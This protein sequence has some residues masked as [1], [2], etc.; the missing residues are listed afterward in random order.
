MIA[1]WRTMLWDWKMLARSRIGVAAALLSLAFVLLATA[2]GLQFAGQWRAQSEA[3]ST[4]ASE[5][6]TRLQADVASGDSWAALPF[7]AQ[8]AIVLP[9]APLADV[10][11][12]RADLDPRVA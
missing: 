1:F 7:N 6:R 10:A 8:S 3:A 12:G 4:E 9:P 11:S 5:A 2:N